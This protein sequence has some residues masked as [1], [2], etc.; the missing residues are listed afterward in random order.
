MEGNTMRLR[1]LMV[2]NI[3][4]DGKEIRQGAKTIIENNNYIRLDENNI[5]MVYKIN[6]LELRI[7]DKSCDFGTVVDSKYAVTEQLLGSG[8]FGD[9][10]YGETRGNKMPIAVKICD[11][12]KVM[13]AIENNIL[14][15]FN[16][17]KDVITTAQGHLNIIKLVDAC[18]TEMHNYLMFEYAAGGD[19]FDYC[20]RYGPL[21]EQEAKH[22]FKQVLEGVKHLHS[23]G[24]PENVLVR[25]PVKYPSILITDFG[26]ARELNAEAPMLNNMCGTTSYMAP[27]VILRSKFGNQLV[28]NI[29]KYDADLATMLNGQ[30]HEQGYGK[31]ADQWSLGLI[32]HFMLTRTLPFE[33]KVNNTCLIH[34]INIFSNPLD[35]DDSWNGISTEAQN[36]ISGLL[37]IDRNLRLTAEQ[38]LESGW[39]TESSEE[40]S[41]SEV[42]QDVQEEEEQKEEI[43]ANS[44]T[45]DTVTKVEQQQQQQ[46][47]E[48]EKEEIK[49]DNATEDTITKAEQQQEEE[50]IKAD[51]TTEDTTTKVEQQEEVAI[52]DEALAKEKEILASDAEKKVSK[53]LTATNAEDEAAQDHTVIPMDQHGV[54]RS[55]S[56]S[57]DQRP[58]KK[59]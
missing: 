54:K 30:F 48:E 16:E 11:K 35:S 4:V 7:S 27:D 6:K 47:E 20:V 49:F 40:F 42:T 14:N 19:L 9:V 15:G 25:R 55:H 29:E 34:I 18:D 59:N 1:N 10:Y 32:L 38:A 23:K 21:S 3:I 37:A 57:S 50:E 43:K 41:E 52:K 26:T 28:K 13:N 45:E 22:I 17:E 53:D 39:F 24:I 31:E 33:I 8:S 58:S 36:L 46:Q 51:N 2:N 12:K 5:L 44:A 56:T